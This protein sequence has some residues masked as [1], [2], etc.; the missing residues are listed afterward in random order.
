MNC[1]SARRLIDAYMDSELDPSA[2][3]EVESHLG[4]CLAC[5]SM[6]E[7]RQELSRAIKVAAT[8]APAPE[9]LRL[10]VRRKTISSP[11]LRFGIA[12]TVLAF[13]IGVAMVLGIWRPWAAQPPMQD[14]ILADVLAHHKESMTC[15]R[16]TDVGSSDPQTIQAWFNKKVD[17]SPCVPKVSKQGFILTG[18]RLDVI[19]GHTAPVLVF[20][21]S[22]HHTDVFVTPSSEIDEF[23]AKKDGLQV[24]SWNDCSLGYW[25]VSDDSI[26]NLVNLR[27]G[28][29]GRHRYR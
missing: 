15:G 4:T 5:R 13:A 3:L 24:L 23:E 20:V 14:R 29:W 11:R 22:G 6:L 9:R 18:G 12:T 8:Y 2:A 28:F 21:N 17:F 19:A 26:E 16:F 10:R 1:Q 27:Q 25:I 7:S